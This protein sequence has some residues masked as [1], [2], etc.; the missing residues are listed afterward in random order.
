MSASFELTPQATEDL[1]AIWWFIAEDNREAADRVET[2]II[3][4]CRRLA[5]HPL[6]GSKRQDITHLGALWDRHEIPQLH[7]CLSPEHGRLT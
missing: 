1:D 6:M 4:T 2:E 5:K 3:A 7:N